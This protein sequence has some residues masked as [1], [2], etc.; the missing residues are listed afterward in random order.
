MTP[1][2]SATAS[3]ADPLDW[4]FAYRA[5]DLRDRFPQPLE[6]FRE[7]LECLQSDRSYMAAMSGDI[8]AY[9]RGGYSLTVPDHFFLSRRSEIDA[10]LI[11]SDQND[12]VCGEVEAWLRRTLAAH[13]KDLPNTVPLEKRPYSLDQLLQQCELEAPELEE[14]KGWH[15]APDVG[16]EIPDAPCERDVWQAAERLF[17]NLEGAKRWML[18]PEIAFSGRTPADVALEDPQQVYDLI[19]RLEHGVYT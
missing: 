5:I 13:E 16:L 10:T 12:A 7:A 1:S 14:L 6:T 11:P 15:D 19:M 3:S 2:G 8:I 17:G 9:L 18:S 4:I